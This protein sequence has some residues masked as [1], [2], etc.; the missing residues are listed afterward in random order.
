MIKD[1][2]QFAFTPQFEAGPESFHR[3]RSPLLGEH[4]RQILQGLLG[5]SPEEIDD[6]DRQGIIGTDAPTATAW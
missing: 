1:E 5:L 6:L 4:N 3:R 2:E